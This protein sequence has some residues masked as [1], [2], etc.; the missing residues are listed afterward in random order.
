MVVGFRDGFVFEAST[1][2]SMFWTAPLV[3]EDGT[4]EA[5]VTFVAAAAA[6][7][8]AD[9]LALEMPNVAEVVV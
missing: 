8:V 7:V 9:G 4:W 5:A 2:T 3:T 1:S 6:A